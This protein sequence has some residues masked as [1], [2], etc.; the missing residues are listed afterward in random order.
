MSWPMWEVIIDEGG[1]RVDIPRIL[2][3]KVQGA[4]ARKLLVPGDNK[5][6]LFFDQVDTAM[7][8]AGWKYGATSESA[9]SPLLDLLALPA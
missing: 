8:A 9:R 1:A 5:G 3:A 6:H 7:R 4:P 2:A